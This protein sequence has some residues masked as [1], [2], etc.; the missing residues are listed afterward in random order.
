MADDTIEALPAWARVDLGS[1]HVHSRFAR[2]IRVEQPS[3]SIKGKYCVGIT[4]PDH[5]PPLF[6]RP[7]EQVV[8]QSSASASFETK[9]SAIDVELW[10][11]GDP[12]TE[13]QIG[14]EQ[15]RQGITEKTP[16][17]GLP[18][19]VAAKSYMGRVHVSIPR[20]TPNRPLHVRAKTHSGAVHIHLPPTFSGLVSWR[21]DQGSLK[22]SPK[23]KQRYVSLGQ[24][25]KHRGVGMVLAEGQ[26]RPSGQAVG[27]AK[28]IAEKKGL[29]PKSDPSVGGSGA[30]SAAT[31]AVNTP[32][33]SRP[34]TPTA[35][36]RSMEG[37]GFPVTEPT[38]HDTVKG[39]LG[40]PATAA[41]TSASM[42]GGA[43]RGD[44]CELISTYGNI[45]VYEVGE[46]MSGTAS[47]QESCTVM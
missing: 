23:I 26:Q 45:N 40:M 6:D 17:K 36:G 47:L 9:G 18:V 11:M 7:V 22:L 14:P 1:G 33:T 38:G 37:Y 2:H 5:F 25:F 39:E 16:A 30:N 13:A 43:T 19:S 24:T 34:G 28:H 4:A 42:G 12:K 20:Y 8:K 27:K 44:A 29:K 35:A 32:S 3:H 31:T 21:S 41:A 46:R 15:H 10:I